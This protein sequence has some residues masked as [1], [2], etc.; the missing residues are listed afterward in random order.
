[1]EA[2][3]SK[4]YGEAYVIPMGYAGGSLVKNPPE[5][6]TCRR[7]GF[8]SW[9]G[10]IPWIGGGLGHALQYS[11]LENPMDRGAWR[12]MV[13]GVAE[14]VTQWYVTELIHTH[15]LYQGLSTNKERHKEGRGGY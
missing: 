9:V 8:D 3:S 1:M 5:S 4:A 7:C 15:R 10:T 6:R 12:A 13:Y 2:Q 11:S 14:S